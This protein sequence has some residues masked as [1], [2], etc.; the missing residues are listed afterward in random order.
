MKQKKSKKKKKVYTGYAQCSTC[1][2]DISIW[3]CVKCNDG[4]PY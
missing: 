1:G 4:H 3:N 2:A